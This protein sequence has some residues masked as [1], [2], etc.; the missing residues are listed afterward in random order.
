MTNVQNAEVQKIIFGSCCGTFAVGS[1][2]K[3]GRLATNLY[4]TEAIRYHHPLKT[5]STYLLISLCCNNWTNGI[6]L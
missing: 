1:S 5:H 3:D 4:R 2:N 6:K